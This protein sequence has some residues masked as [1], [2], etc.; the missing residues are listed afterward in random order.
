[1]DIN[2]CFILWVSY[3]LKFYFLIGE[4]FDYSVRMEF[5]EIKKKLGEGGFG[6]VYLA[7]DQLLKQEV[8]VKVLNFAQN[9]KNSHMITKEIE[10]LSQLKHKN[11]VKLLDYFALPKK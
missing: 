9:I 6:A 2:I 8:A 10:A 4:D 11:I 3:I 5:I 1:M 7:Y